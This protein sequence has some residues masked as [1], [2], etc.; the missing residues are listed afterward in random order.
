M[1]KNA[2]RET[3]DA[4]DTLGALDLSD[5]A[6]GFRSFLRTIVREL[7][8]NVMAEEA[9]SLCG[10]KY[11]PKD[12]Q[13][14]RAGSAPGYVLFEGN[15]ENVRR[16]RV[17]KK[18]PDGRTEETPLLTYTL[19]QDPSELHE[20]ILRALLAGVP[21]RE[22]KTLH[23]PATPGLSKSE[24]SRLWI[25][26]G[27]RILD[28]FR[29]RD[30]GSQNWLAL[31]IDGIGLSGDVLAVVA[32]GITTGGEKMLLDFEIGSSESAEVC[33]GLMQRLKE[34]GFGPVPGHRL[35][36][37][38]DGSAALRKGL[39]SCFPETAVQRCLVHKERNLCGYLSKRHWGTVKGLL[40]RLRQVEGAEAAREVL[41][42]LRA[43]L[44]KTNAAALA[45]LEEAGDDLI[46]LHLLGAPATLHGSLLSTNCI[47]NPFR[48]VRG[49]LGRVSRW[50]AETEQPS[51][52]LAY[53]LS[54]V[55]KG[56]RRIRGYRDLARLLEALRL[57][58]GGGVIGSTV[59]GVPLRA[60]PSASPPEPCL[61]AGACGV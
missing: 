43:F 4:Q 20:Q 37:V 45:S 25:K 40:K 6:T 41:G 53:A 46:R 52:W 44:Q 48:N 16:P 36:A 31:M 12:S 58:G 49:K 26:E 24:V 9:A 38:T 34:R 21:S 1:G 54:V 55:E 33:T 59:P 47:E 19:A 29:S 27:A 3:L 60:S 56:F 32:L 15:R 17:R 57:P 18:H 39:L 30:I 10:Q 5:V 13:H 61:T 14:Y 35:F 51:R 2:G 22:Q 8:V 28:E 7:L 11:K 50:R 42:E 23:A